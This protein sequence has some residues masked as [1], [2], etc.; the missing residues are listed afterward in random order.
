MKKITAFIIIPYLVV[1]AVSFYIFFGPG[2]LGAYEHLDWKGIMTNVPGGF[3][4]RDYQDG[5]WE[6]YSLRK[7]FVTMKIALG[8]AM[9]VSRLPRGLRKVK[10]QTSPG[11]GRIFYIY[12]RRKSYEAV[13]A[14]TLKD[15]TV[16]YSV[17]SGSVFSATRMLAKITAN[18]FY[19]GDPIT[20]VKPS[21]PLGAYITDII[22]FFGMLLPVFIILLVVSLSGK[23]PAAKYFSGDPI[24]CQESF[25]YFTGVRKFR[26]S[27]SLCYL[28]LTSTRLMVFVFRKPSW[29]IKLNEGASGI[30]IEGKKIILEKNKEKAILRPQD[31]EKWKECLAPYLY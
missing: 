3:K 18:N 30:R 5:V 31:I 4:V 13:F 14:Q 21:L 26:R 2:L 8:P 28:A 27:T 9:D 6:V 24:R 25:V 1:V 10:Y 7:I 20:P 11:P 22:F 16:F 15:K 23:K 19:Q 12:S 29:E 17:A